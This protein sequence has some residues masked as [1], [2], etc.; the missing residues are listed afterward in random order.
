MDG[1]LDVAADRQFLRADLALYL[2]PFG[3]HD[4]RGAYLSLDMTK[5]SQGPIADNLADDR[6]TR[7]NRGGRFRLQRIRVVGE[8]ASFA[9]LAEIPRASRLQFTE[10]LRLRELMSIA[11]A[12]VFLD[13]YSTFLPTSRAVS[14][15]PSS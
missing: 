5:N 13:R 14:P 2:C 7:T 12:F 1:A 4:G 8:S 6:K 10:A 11:L 15:V 3:D 9:T